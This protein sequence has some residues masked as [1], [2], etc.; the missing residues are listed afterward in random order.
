[1]SFP[2]IE[3]DDIDDELPDVID[4]KQLLDGCSDEQ[5][6]SAL[7]KLKMLY[8]KTFHTAVINYYEE[9]N[10]ALEMLEKAIALKRSVSDVK[11]EDLGNYLELKEEIEG[12]G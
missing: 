1:M 4:Q 5:R 11:D 10:L 2:Y 3:N 8:R 6:K 9:N 7:R 12:E